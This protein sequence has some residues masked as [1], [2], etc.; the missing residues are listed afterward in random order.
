MRDYTAVIMAGGFGT[1]IQPLTHSTPKPMLPITNIP[2]M[3]H[4]LEKL[5]DIGMKE[6]VI[7]LYYK[8]DIIKDYFG[9]GSKWGIKINY[10]LPES[11]YGT[12][13]AVGCAREYLNKPFLVIS[14]DLVTDF[15]LKKI[16]AFHEKKNSKLTITLTTVDNPLQFGI[17]IVNENGRI[18]RFLEKPSWGEVFSDTIN[19]GIYVIEPE[20]LDYIPKNDTFDFSKNLFP[21]LMKK[22]IT[23]Y[24]YTAA[25]YW[26]DVGNPDSY[27]DVHTDIFNKKVKFN[28]PGKRIRCLDGVLHLMGEAR[29]D[30]SVEIIGEVVIGNNV[31]IGK[32][33]KLHNCSV[34]NNV[35]IGENAKIRDS[36]IW[37]NV[38]IG[39]NS[40]FD[41]SV[42][43]KNVISEEN[44]IAK[45]G[46]V[47]AENVKV[48]KLSRFDKDITIWP[49]KEI[50]PASIVTNNV[51]WGT[52]HK[53]SIFENG[54]AKG[55]ANIEISCEMACKIGEAFG[56]LLPNGS[57]IMIGR[58]NAKNARMLKRAFVGGILATGVDVVDLKAIAPSIVRY[59]I[60]RFDEAIGG[61]YFRVSLHSPADVEI[62]LYNEHGLRINSNIAKA[63]EKTYFSEN[64]KRVD[65]SEI[66]T[67]HDYDINTYE[68]IKSYEDKIKK[69]IDHKIIKSQDFKVAVDLMFGIT[70]DI[71]PKLLTDIQIDNIMLNAYTD[72]KKLENIFSYKEKA[73]ENISKIVKAL[74]CDMGVMIYP[75]GQRLTLVT[76]KGEVLDKVRALLA[77]LTLL[78]FEAESNKE[79]YK[80]FLPAWA[81]DCMDEKFVNLIIER[82]KYSS[83][84]AKK[85]KTYNLIATID[86]NFAFTKFTL[87]RDAM[88]STLKIMEM[89][90]RHSVTLSEISKDIKDFY[91]YNEKIECPQFK[92]GTVMKEFLKV[93]KMKK[94]KEDGGIKIF[95]ERGWILMIPDE[96][97]EH[98]NI[99]IQ[100]K[101]E[102]TGKE[103]LNKYKEMIKKWTV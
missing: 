16:F 20:I 98:L 62:I 55:K 68:Y 22:G 50:E 73:K 90:T 100:A 28:F 79:V 14:G 12:A 11:D 26:R 9:N 35:I 64:Y 86:G 32:G 48:G 37:E 61:A 95:E 2:M 101:D 4:I 21:A 59:N 43:C 54:T 81:P 66:G 6:V 75:H 60:S 91:Y 36:I 1:R 83:F 25:G 102:K 94:Y 10:V 38:K 5:V 77:V 85:L 71:F 52:K 51:V 24:G 46:C 13:G 17:V 67:I 63:I 88:F 18:E 49:D 78:N 97:S 34:G 80:V 58:D 74:N 23:L 84:E 33:V 27:R 3:E 40:V 93:A 47:I 30:K 82:G 29:I 41:Y 56:S 39:R 76:E 65:F 87:F 53:N 96:F 89:L 99:Y 103:I 31:E 45:N 72:E 8:P 92:K 69:I 15:D 7:L 44:V 57:K 19:T 42:I 70:K